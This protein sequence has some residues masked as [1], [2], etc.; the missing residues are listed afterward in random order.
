VAINHS[1]SQQP[2]SAK[3]PTT[4]SLADEDAVR[5]IVTDTLFG[6]WATVNNLTRLR[7]SKRER[8]RVTVFGSART[9]PG[10]WVYQ[11]VKHM[12][13]ALSA[14][15]CDIV[16]GGGPGLM[17]AAN[18]GAK[19]ANAS[20]RVQSVGI[21]VELPFEQEVNPFVEQAFE[22]Q[23]FF[24]RLHHFVLLSDAFIVAPG[25]IG[26]VLESMMIWQLL[27]VRHL[28]DT[29]LIFAGP[30]WKGLVDWAARMMLRPGFELANPEDMKIPRCVDNAEQAIAIV[31]EHHTR[32][33]AAQAKPA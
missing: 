22:H 11:E 21:R 12:A 5:R 6:L 4:V 10:H 23:T 14:M 18:E 2:P 15:G 27:Q 17:Q 9:E 30:M 26:T 13:A 20:E 7:P 19:E 16:T 8:Y 1:V 29:P 3:R 32:W 33:Q 28:H 25:G 31:R 24:T